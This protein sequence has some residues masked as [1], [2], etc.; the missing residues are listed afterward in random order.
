MK[1]EE[2]VTPK[3]KREFL[4]LPVA[5]YKGTPQWIRPLDSDIEDVFD[6]KR[7]RTFRHGQCVRWLLR[8]DNGKVIGRVAA[9]VNDKTADRV[10]EQRTGGLGFFEC[11]ENKEAAFILFDTC[12]H[13]LQS[14]GMEAM[15]GPVNFGERDKW[16]GLLIEGFEHEPNYQCN[17]HP[18]YYKTFFEE[19][20]FQVYF[21]QLTFGRESR[22]PL[23]EKVIKKAEIC[24]Q[25][26]DYTF[27]YLP[28]KEWEKLPELIRTIYNKAWANRL[29]IPELSEANVK[30]LVEKMRPI[31][32]E[33]LLWFGYYKGEP[34]AFFLAVPEVNQVLRYVNGKLDWIG[35][36]KF[37][38]YNHWLKDRKALGLLFGVV[39][40]HQGKGVDGALIESAH[41]V[42]RLKPMVYAGIELNWIGDFN[43]KMLRVAEQINTVK[44]KTH[45]TYRL[46]FDPSKPFKRMPYMG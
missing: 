8:N 31:L 1:P 3:Q 39:P 17:Y 12:K 7:N 25:N 28:K 14:K 6:E 29:E 35:K 40:D 9:F 30:H 2:V 15:D 19:Y 44:V 21:N 45:A 20:G 37:M 5:L 38:W 22:Y 24:R 33:K 10:T 27:S 41:K 26:K 42:Y 13:W 34:I 46:L 36:L 32:V 43:Q 4:L 16:W 18:A 11:I 23:T